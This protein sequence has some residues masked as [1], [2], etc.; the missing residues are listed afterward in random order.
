MS[1]MMTIDDSSTAFV[2]KVISHMSGISSRVC[3]HADSLKA[4]DKA[5]HGLL[6]DTFDEYKA[7]ADNQIKVFDGKQGRS[8]ASLEHKI[9]YYKDKYPNKHLFVFVDSFHNLDDVQASGMSTYQACNISSK[10]LKQ[11]VTDLGVHIFTTAHVR[12]GVPGVCPTKMDLSDTGKIDY[13]ALATWM[14]HCEAADLG[15]NATKF[16]HDETDLVQDPEWSPGDSEANKMIPR[17]KPIFE[18]HIVKDKKEL[19]YVPIMLKLDGS[20]NKFTTMTSDEI[21]AM[22]KAAERETHNIPGM[23]S[24]GIPVN[25]TPNVYGSI[26]GRY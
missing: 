2:S 1:I 7:L 10:K 4:T 5:Q 12:K 13:D 15:N 19:D 18:I 8:L 26:P 22:K 14:C 20:K 17:R 16:W 21:R 6:L 24:G 25:N 3:L 11:L 9:R 23:F